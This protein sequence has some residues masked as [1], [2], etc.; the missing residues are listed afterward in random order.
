MDSI[1]F[2]G[3]GGARFVMAQQL[4]ATGGLWLRLNGTEISLDPGPGA[5]V[6][7]KRKRLDPSRLAGILISHRHLDH[8]G[9]AN[10]MIEAM[11]QGGTRRHGVVYAP[12][13]ALEEDPVVLRY[14]RPYVEKVVTL[15][16][17]QR[18]QVGGM[19]FE[20]SMP[21]LHG[22][23]ETF[24]F[25]FF[26]GH[27][28]VSY[29]PDTSY[30]PELHDFYRSDVLIMAVLLLEPRPN[31]AHL[32]VPEAK[33]IILDLKPQVAIL[34]HF[35]ATMWQAKPWE[36]AAR[37]SEETGVRVIAARDGMEYPLEQ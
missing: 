17:Y 1:I 6:H 29:L 15:K 21:H 9:D 24:G 34:T 10:A 30:F 33:E 26:C 35:G 3:T 22:D 25:R 4:L 28:V 14:L 37:L 12:G 19:A 23:V 16:P 32:S 20:T 11:T 2:L 8:C 5:I 18:Y 7:A 27:K 36:I 13:D 31:V